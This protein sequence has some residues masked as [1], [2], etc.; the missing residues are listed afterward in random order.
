MS[1]SARPFSARGRVLCISYANIR[2]EHHRKNS[3]NISLCEV[4]SPSPHNQSLGGFF[5]DQGR[6]SSLRPL[7]ASQT[8]SRAESLVLDELHVQKRP[9][10][11]TLS[12]DYTTEYSDGFINNSLR[13][14]RP[15]SAQFQPSPASQLNQ[16]IKQNIK[17]PQCLVGKPPSQ[18]HR[19]NSKPKQAHPNF[20]E[21]PPPSFELP[22]SKFFT[23]ETC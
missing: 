3:S 20:R 10:A 13:K 23:E 22:P 21:P 17:R 12:R 6:E 16:N 14:P 4:V 8:F 2:P 19:P 18:L 11:A 15:K 5:F 7:S 9:T 1:R